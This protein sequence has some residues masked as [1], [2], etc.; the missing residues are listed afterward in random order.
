MKIGLLWASLT[1]VVLVM[2]DAATVIAGDGT[3]AFNE[4]GNNGMGTAGSGDVL[5]GILAA[6]S[7]EACR[8]NLTPAECANAAV[9]LHGTA[10]DL[11]ASDLGCRSLTAG[12]L[13]RYI[14]RAL[15][16]SA[17]PE[18]GTEL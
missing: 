3:L 2:K 12:D 10:G 14:P 11:A 13:V 1:D 15:G 9:A 6:L 18:K 8:N 7:N 5:A 17:A 16:K 4:T